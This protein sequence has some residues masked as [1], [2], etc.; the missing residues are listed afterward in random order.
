MITISLCMIV[1]NEEKVLERCLQSVKG[2]PDEIIIVDTGSTD[3]TKEIAEKWTPYVY[4][5]K[6]IDDFS[7]ARNESFRHATKDYILWLDADDVLLEKDKMALQS[8][9]SS[10]HS[11]IDA[12]AMKYHA[13][14][15]NQ[16]NVIS[17]A[18]RFR[19]L[20]R[21]KQY[22]WIGVV[23][24][25]IPIT[26]RDNTYQSTIVVTHQKENPKR[27]VR[28]LNIYEKYVARGG[29]LTSHDL[30]HYGRELASNHRYEEAVD[31]FHQ[32]LDSPH[33][34][35]EMRLF[36]FNELASCYYFLQNIEQEHQIT[37]Q[38]LSYDMPQP[39]FCCR[40]GEHFLRQGKVE[41]A[42]FWYQLA[43]QI[44]VSYSWSVDKNPFRTW[45]PHKQLGLCY[46]MKEEDRQALKYYQ[47]VLEFLPDDPEAKQKIQY[48]Q[49]KMKA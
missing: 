2:I 35:D 13:H 18:Y 31:I 27:S 36:I 23:H 4:D 40:L 19:L 6:W 12:V 7:A 32:F 44:P 39:V 16:G 26:E 37:L 47:Q 48:L 28:N 20:K 29:T 30:F 41:V 9:K 11:E 15:D 46:E 8:L 22:R 10:L 33:V 17:S 34:S 38:S 3:R 42:I 24:E 5:F 14:F 21:E 49:Q 25:H 43:I 45:L 1:K